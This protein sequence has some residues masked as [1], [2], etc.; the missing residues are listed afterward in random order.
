M[1]KRA[2]IILTAICL[3]FLLIIGTI[4]KRNNDKITLLTH[5]LEAVKDSLTTSKLENGDLLSS[6]QTLILDKKE[7]SE[8]LN[9]SKNTIKEIEKTLNSKIAHIAK[10]E[11]Q[12]KLK[13]TI[14]MKPDTV[15]VKE[16]YTIKKFTWHDEWAMVKSSVIGDNVN[17]SKMTIDKLY[18]NT[19]VEVGLTEDYN[20]W[21]KT[22]NPYIVI[23][24]ITSAVIDGSPIKAKD[25]R[26]HHGI[27][28]GFGFNYGLF[29]RSWDFGP[30]AGYGFMY[31]F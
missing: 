14:W 4:V 2:C 5:N 12:I 30:H 19:P 29:N 22:P 28:V 9:I 25:K 16:N 13:D 8:E 20:F 24:G 11:A 31:S 23:N 26:F 10:L 15:Y 1:T 21:V 18:I 3:F 27:Y 17:N 7:L 6:K